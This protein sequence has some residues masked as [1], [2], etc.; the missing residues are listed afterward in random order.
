MTAWTDDDVAL[1]LRWVHMVAPLYWDG[2]SDAAVISA[3]AWQME[4]DLAERDNGGIKN[5]IAQWAPAMHQA[6]GTM[7]DL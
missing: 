7:R 2:A 6:A 4:F 5:L 3:L 1:L